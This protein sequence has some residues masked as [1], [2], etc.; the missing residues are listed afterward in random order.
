MRQ[1]DALAARVQQQIESAEHGYYRLVLVVGGSGTG[2]TAALRS[3]ADQRSAGL[4]NVGAALS[5]MLIGMSAQ[6]RALR[7]GDLLTRAVNATQGRVLLLDNTEILFAPELRID[8][9]R[10]LQTAS[11]SRTMV[12]SW[13]GQSEGTVLSFAAPRHPEYRRYLRPEVVCVSTTSAE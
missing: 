3:V 6:Q 12:A 1:V 4:L 2:K 8:P 7:A 9:L 11:R 13:S 5:E 10:L